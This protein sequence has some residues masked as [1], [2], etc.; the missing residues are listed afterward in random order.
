[1]KQSTAQIKEKLRD[2]LPELRKNYNVV[3]LGVFGSVVKGNQTPG[4]DIDMLVTFS[5]PPSFFKFIRLETY[6]HKIL[7]RR[8]DLVT[9]KA[10]KNTIK[11]EILQDVIYV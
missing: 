10:L 6:L 4:S 1:M 5:T 11:E 8:V 3:K 9:E 2:F 7:K